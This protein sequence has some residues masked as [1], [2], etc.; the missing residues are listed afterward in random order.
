MPLLGRAAIAMWWDITPAVRAEFEDW[1]SHEHLPERLGIPGFRRAT[2]WGDAAGGEGVFVMYELDDHDVL[3]SEPYLAS[4]NAPTP[5]SARMMPLHRHMVRSQCRVLESAGGAVARHALTV[6]LSPLAGREDALRSVLKAH[7]DALPMR[8]GVVGA[9]LLRHQAPPIATT[10]EQ[11]IRGLL[12]R[13]ADWVMVIC[14]YDPGVLRELARETFNDK[15]LQQA[16]AAEG[17][18]YGV[19]SLAHSATPGDIG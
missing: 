4:L 1:H 12:D 6:R 17:A 9:H 8:P 10:T 15:A 7:I 5:W 2:R 13:V 18:S 14:G 16:G 11:R 3:S 19:Y